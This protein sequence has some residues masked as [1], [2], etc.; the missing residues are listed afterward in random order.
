MGKNHERHESGEELRIMVPI[1]MQEP[2]NQ[3][4]MCAGLNETVVPKTIDKNRER[5]K[6]GEE[7]GSVVPVYMQEPDSDVCA[8]G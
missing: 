3:T 8:P 1:Y 7:S 2:E 6:S 4:Q 5:H